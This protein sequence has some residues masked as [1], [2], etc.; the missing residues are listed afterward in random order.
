MSCTRHTSRVG[1]VAQGQFWY[2]TSVFFLNY[3]SNYYVEK[4]EKMF[5]E[6]IILELSR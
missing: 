2:F 1:R 3:F 6:I 4:F 5:E